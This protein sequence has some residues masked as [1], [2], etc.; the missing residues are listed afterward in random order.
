MF[1]PFFRFNSFDQ[2]GSHQKVV[3]N[4]DKANTS[5]IAAEGIMN[6]IMKMHTAWEPFLSKWLVFFASFRHYYL[7]IS[8]QRARTAVM[9]AAPAPAL[10]AAAAAPAHA[11]LSAIKA[12]KYRQGV[13]CPQILQAL[14]LKL[15]MLGNY[16]QVDLQMYLK[17]L[18][19][20]DR[21]Y[22]VSQL[23]TGLSC[24]VEHFH[25]VNGSRVGAD[26]HV[27]WKVPAQE[28]ERDS[29]ATAR[30][31]ADCVDGQSNTMRM[32]R[33]AAS[34]FRNHM[35]DA[36]LCDGVAAAYAIYQ[37]LACT[38]G[39]ALMPMDRS[40]VGRKAWLAAQ[41]VIESGDQDLAYDLRAYNGRPRD[42]AFEKFWDKLA[43][44]LEKYKQP[45]E[46]RHGMQ[47]YCY[48]Y[49][50]LLSL[51]VCVFSLMAFVLATCILPT[52]YLRRPCTPCCSIHVIDSGVDRGSHE[53][54]GGRAGGRADSRGCRHQDTN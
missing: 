36:N 51:H 2:L 41:L 3:T 49:P 7:R 18:N 1:D 53:G 4:Y 25:W 23:K 33:A 42:G 17:A 21:S 30:L 22:F 46:R 38:T 29:A 32:N 39:T 44:M 48:P 14:D 6:H 27:V 43:D 47:A 10:T 24:C 16:R 28:S 19:T 11:N 5:F 37:F 35:T 26:S 13:A 45:H 34:L 9:H 31:Y 40:F 50:R 8:R 54:A 52:T 12:R 15:G 20:R